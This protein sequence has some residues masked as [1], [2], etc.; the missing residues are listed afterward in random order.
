M[1]LIRRKVPV[2]SAKAEFVVKPLDMSRRLMW[3]HWRG[4]VATGK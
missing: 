1:N 2:G 4:V 3:K